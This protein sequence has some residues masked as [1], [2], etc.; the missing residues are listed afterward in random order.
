M[1]YKLFDKKTGFDVSVNEELAEEWH[2][3]IIK[4]SK[5]EKSMGDLK[6]IF[7]KLT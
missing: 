4:S 6:T 2:K 5:E 7:S 1:V 3:R